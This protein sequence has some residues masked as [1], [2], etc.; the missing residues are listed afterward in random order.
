MPTAAVLTIS[1]S[2]S[3]GTRPDTSGPAAAEKLRAAG[4]DVLSTEIIPDELDLINN[5]MRALCGRVD[6]IVTTGG[7]GVAARDV[8]PEAAAAVIERPLPGFG[9]IMRTAT[10]ENTPLSIIAR[11]GAGIT[12]R[13]LI[14]FLPGSP[15]AVGECLDLVLPAARHVIEVLRGESGK[16][17]DK[18][19]SDQRR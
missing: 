17:G 13:T 10:F 9:E 15:K 3:T 18:Q 19:G 6:L 7:T 4:F 2:R 12:G 14:I 16:C 1:D 8:T 5:K 11:S